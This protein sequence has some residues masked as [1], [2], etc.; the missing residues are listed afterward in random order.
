[1]YPG[2]GCYKANCSGQ[3][4]I[5][6]CQKYCYN[7]SCPEILSWILTL[8]PRRPFSSPKVGKEVFCG[9]FIGGD[10]L[11][12]T[13]IGVIHSSYKTKEDAP[14]QGRFAEETVELEIYNEY[15]A[16]L[17]DIELNFLR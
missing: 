3:K 2:E 7:I 6:I 13:A 9:F 14:F 8:K 11:E 15:A 10:Y 4:F 1:V 17:K 16:G 5:Y 12:L